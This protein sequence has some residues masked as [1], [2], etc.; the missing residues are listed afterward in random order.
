MSPSSH[1]KH[2]RFVK[3]FGAERHFSES[4]ERNAAQLRRQN[5]RRAAAVHTKV[6]EG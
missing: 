5:A 4:A 2:A 3:R 1:I 6:L